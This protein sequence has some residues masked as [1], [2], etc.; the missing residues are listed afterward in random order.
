MLEHFLSYFRI[1]C[2]I[3]TESMILCHLVNHLIDHIPMWNTV[4]FIM[5]H[6]KYKVCTQSGLLLLL[7]QSGMASYS[8]P[9]A[10]GPG[11]H[12]VRDFG[13]NVTLRRLHVFP[14]LW[15]QSIYFDGFPNICHFGPEEQMLCG[16]FY[17]IQLN[18]V[19]GFPKKIVIFN[20]KMGEPKT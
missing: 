14:W 16:Q 9:M 10:V 20:L 4:L 15:A 3:Q 12:L 13:F 5:L 6:A 8:L 19:N 11:N 2:V 18:I 17:V 1:P 7:A